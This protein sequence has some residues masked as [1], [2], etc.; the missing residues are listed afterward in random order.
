MSTKQGPNNDKI[1]IIVVEDDIQKAERLR[2]TLK[3]PNYN[4]RFVSD[5]EEALDELKNLEP[6]LI[7]SNVDALAMNGFELCSKIKNDKA[8]EHILVILLSD[9]SDPKSIIKGLSLKADSYIVDPYNNEYLLSKIT[10]LLKGK[11]EQNNTDSQEWLVVNIDGEQHSIAANSQQMNLFLTSTYENIIYQ[12]REL[13][14]T[15]SKLIKLDEEYDEKELE[16]E[17]S[18]AEL[19]ANEDKFRSFVQ[20]LPDLVYQI[21]SKGHFTFVNDAVENFGYTPEELIG[22]HFDTIIVPVDSKEVNRDEVLNKNILNPE[23]EENTPKFFDERRTGER[24]TRGLEVMVVPKDGGVRTPAVIN[25]IGNEMPIVEISSSGLYE[26]NIL[27]GLKDLIG[28]V[29]IVRDITERKLVEK[30]IHELNKELEHAVVERTR[31]LNETN[32]NLV[33]TLDELN[34]TQQ[35]VIQSEKLASLGAMI[36]G[37]AHELNNA[38]TGILYCVQYVRNHLKDEKNIQILQKAEREIHR[39]DK[40][41]SSMLTYSRP[42]KRETVQVNIV[43]VIT[44]AVD[45]LDVHYKKKGIT[46]TVNLQDTLPQAWA[47]SDS[48]QQVILNLLINAF[49]SLNDSPVKEVTIEANEVDDGLIIIVKDTGPGVPDE[50]IKKIFDPFFT[51]KSPGKGTGLGLSVSQNIITGFDGA[52]SV[53]NIDGQGAMFTIN[54]KTKSPKK[55][56]QLSPT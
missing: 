24:S 6:N 2:K 20:M 31:E 56:L 52:L 1:E 37:T 8:L 39:S 18:R 5:G 17:T 19:K 32:K 10:S 14:N 40:I 45:L 51:T 42:A 54:L 9:M 27:T 30:E 4:V 11:W 26:S 15:Q 38:M 34:I 28:S 12:N 29:G 50:V 22:K 23:G 16:L 46:L 36:A 21:D 25:P 35:Q 13:I 47:N 3:D 55:K 43:D 48:L 49:D 33:K 53:K 7:I 44:R 41:I